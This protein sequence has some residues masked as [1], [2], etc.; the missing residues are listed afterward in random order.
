LFVGEQ[1]LKILETHPYWKL[2]PDHRVSIEAEK[3][4]IK[5]WEDVQE[6]EQNQR[7]PNKIIDKRFVTQ[8]PF[9]ALIGLAGF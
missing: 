9:S 4:T 5:K 6:D 2:I 3:N 8:V 7:W 1:I